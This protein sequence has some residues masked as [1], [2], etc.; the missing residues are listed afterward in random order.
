MGPL[1]RV[2]RSA[3]LGFLRLPRRVLR[4]IV[5]PPIRSPEGFDLDLQSQALLWLMRA[6]REP[7][8]YDANLE[9]ARGRLDH[10]AALLAPTNA[11]ALHVLD[12]EVDGAAGPRPCR[13]YRPAAL[14]GAL[15]P[16]LVWF[17]GGGFVLGSLASY[18]GVC[19]ALAGQAGVAIV[20]VDYRLA[21]EHPFPAGLE[22]AVAA[23]R[24]I[25]DHGEA[26]GV[27]SRRIAIGG[28]SAGGNF[29]AG[30]AQALRGARRQPSFQ[31]LVYPATDATRREPS[32]R[33]FR[34][35]FIL[36][37]D[38]IVWFLAHYLAGREL[39]RDPRVSPVFSQD[40]SGLPPALVMIAGFDPLR[41]EGA[42]YAR[43]MTDAAGEVE[44]VRSEGSMHG[45]LNTAGAIEES[46]RLL[47]L[48]ADRL[49]RRLRG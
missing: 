33:H 29:A 18:D 4:R 44:T 2:E 22:D 38:N 1:G 27:D 36:S 6:R 9:K 19:R 11:Y 37:E 25:L 7:Q 40:F 39:T 28:D 34:S 49:R 14:H 41:D 12:G 46:A 8:M 48:A 15:V 43:R 45:F 10:N 32:H 24:W 47:A 3:A 17:H 13:V 42:L 5:G 35:G 21:P 23:T 26:L 31:L 30:V 16:G 20:A